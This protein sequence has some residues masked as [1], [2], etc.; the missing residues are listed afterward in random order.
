MRRLGNAFKLPPRK[1][2]GALGG[3]RPDRRDG[4]AD[5][6]LGRAHRAAQGHDVYGADPNHPVLK[7]RAPLL[8]TIRP[9][10]NLDG[11][12]TSH[13]NGDAR[14]GATPRFRTYTA[15]NLGFNHGPQ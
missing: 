4:E 1:P 7:E 13:E 5:G 8:L 9:R 15:P 12:A 2:K 10:R 14:K 3:E 6:F 11:R